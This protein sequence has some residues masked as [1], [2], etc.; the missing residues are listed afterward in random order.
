MA[1]A[2]LPASTQQQLS[3]AANPGCSRLSGGSLRPR[4]PLLPSQ[5]TLPEGSS[6]TRGFEWP[7]DRAAESPGTEDRQQ[8]RVRSPASVCA[9]HGSG[10]DPA[11]LAAAAPACSNRHVPPILVDLLGRGQRAVVDIRLGLY[12]A[13]VGAAVV[14]I[15]RSQLFQ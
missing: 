13:L 7:D 15:R 11:L 14:R 12:H 5:E 1:H 3:G 6:F 9:G 10:H 4:T 2:I 8:Q